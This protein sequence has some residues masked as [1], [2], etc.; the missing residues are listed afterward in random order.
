ME[1][2]DVTWIVFVDALWFLLRALLFAAGAE[3]P[4]RPSSCYDVA[5]SYVIGG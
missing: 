3:P 5:A 2:S 4:A 1:L